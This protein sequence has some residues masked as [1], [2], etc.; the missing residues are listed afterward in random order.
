MSLTALS[1]LDNRYAGQL[2]DLADCFS[3]YTLIAQRVR[4]EIEWLLFQSER[5]EL[6]HV[7]PFTRAE[8][9]LLQS[10]IAAFDD[11]QAQ[12][13]S[14]IERT[15]DHD[16]KAV[17]YYLKE[18]LSKTT[19]ADVREAVHFGCT[20][21][22]IN[23]LAHALM[24][25]TGI[26]TVW[27]PLA[28][29][30]V[31]TVADRARATRNLPMLAHTHGQPA[32]PTT[33][34]KELAVF[35]YRWQRQ[36]AQMDRIEYLGKFN[37]A[38]GNYN[39]HV[40]ACPGLPWE[41]IARAFV[42]RLG[43]A[44]NPLT[45][46]IEPHDFMAELFHLIIRFNTIALDFCRD[47]WAYIALGY[48]RQQVVADQVGSSTMPHKINPIQFENAEANLGIS[49][50]L[51]EHLST[52]LPVSRLQRD[53][54]DSSAIRNIG[55]AIGHACLALQSAHKGFARTDADTAAI[56]R[57]LSSEWAVLG[58]AIQTTMRKAGL[59]NPYERLKTFTRGTAITRDHLCTFIHTLDLPETDKQRLLAL[60]PETYIGLAPVL[61][62]HIAPRENKPVK[63]QR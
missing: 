30:L 48:F 40:T 56:H 22:D 46:Q 39:A 49:T 2:A 60:T 11:S 3:Q 26:E 25:K 58:E 45:T 23:N 33:L 29:T 1:P 24:L 38:T 12:R 61:V 43:L 28:E 37:G 62:D 57:A 31:H 13:I 53:L 21:E 41:R 50:A 9:D 4:V 59:D 19:L 27:R 51:L 42:E 52:K 63:S 34:G 7:R 54:S 47:M 8:C 14:E 20:S 44:F 35:V 6:A 18:R 5:P 36:L 32:T 16:V 55:P 17:E 10:W 15:T